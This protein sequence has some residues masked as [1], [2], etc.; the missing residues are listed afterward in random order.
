MFLKGKFS[1]MTRCLNSKHKPKIEE[2]IFSSDHNVIE[3]L[4]D[5]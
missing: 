4:K 2:I 3:K 5:K 1:S